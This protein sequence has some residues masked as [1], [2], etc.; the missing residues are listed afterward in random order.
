MNMF[1]KINH[2]CNH[3]LEIAAK[4]RYEAKIDRLQSDLNKACTPQQLEVAEH[5][6]NEFRKSLIF[7]YISADNSI[8]N[9]VVWK[10]CQSCG[11]YEVSFTLNGEDITIE[12]REID[13]LIAHKPTPKEFLKAIR[14]IICKAITDKIA[15]NII[16][17]VIE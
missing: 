17:K 2:N 15:D 14:E 5:I 3:D 4:Q 9:L 16:M 6:A 10:M 1:D 12:L 11:S 13:H 7:E 8:F